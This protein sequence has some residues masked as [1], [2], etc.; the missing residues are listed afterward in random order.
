MSTN[1]SDEQAHEIYYIHTM[2]EY[3]EIKKKNKVP[4]YATKQINLEHAILSKRSQGQ[5]TIRCM[6]SFI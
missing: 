3:A 6:I 2:G 4:I 1:I 5:K